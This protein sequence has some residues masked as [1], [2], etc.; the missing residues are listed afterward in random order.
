M[1]KD[2]CMTDSE[3]AFTPEE[4]ASQVPPSVD[5]HMLQSLLGRN[6]KRWLDA[7]SAAMPP[8]T[9]ERMGR[10]AETAATGA[11]ERLKRQMPA[12]EAMSRELLQQ[13]YAD[14]PSEPAMN[15]LVAGLALS[16][17]ANVPAPT[18]TSLLEVDS[19]TLQTQPEA[20]RTPLSQVSSQAL[21]RLSEAALATYGVISM[22]QTQSPREVAQAG[23]FTILL[24]AIVGFIN[25]ELKRR[26]DSD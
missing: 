23:S 4:E 5:V 17:N 12:L 16:M 15:S 20:S 19:V 6:A 21:I 22:I 24:L 25:S 14:F 26:G 8:G 7:L 11:A 1:G 9:I 13:L 2:Q 3:D 10:T 18:M